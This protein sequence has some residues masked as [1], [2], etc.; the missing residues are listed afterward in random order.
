[1][2][3]SAIESFVWRFKVVCFS[4][5]LLPTFQHLQEPHDAAVSWAL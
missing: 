5:L 2:V 3:K 4:I 1:M